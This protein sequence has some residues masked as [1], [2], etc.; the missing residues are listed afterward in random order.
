MYKQKATP[1][2]PALSVFLSLSFSK[3]YVRTLILYL[4]T[5]ITA[6]FT[7]L[8]YIINT[9]NVH[10]PHALPMFL[11]GQYTS[12]EVYVHTYI[13]AS[14]L[15]QLLLGRKPIRKG[16]SSVELSSP[17]LSNSRFIRLIKLHIRY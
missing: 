12:V 4:S 11:L 5:T 14:V 8:C 2:P 1:L 17:L 7:I 3:T 16:S 13:I 15:T 6:K 9:E 10:I